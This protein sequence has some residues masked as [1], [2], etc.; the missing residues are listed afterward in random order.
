MKPAHPL[1][2]V[3]A[4]TTIALHLTIGPALA[5]P[6]HMSAALEL[7]QAAKKSD[8]P[9]PMLQAARKH[10]ENAKKNKEGER[11]EALRDVKEAMAQ[12]QV[13]DL[14]KMEQKINSAIANIHQGK[15]KAK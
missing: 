3:L 10:L 4:V 9:M 15:D 1:F 2:L 8:K 14:K 5:E 7:L 13:G 12:A 6:P 11:V